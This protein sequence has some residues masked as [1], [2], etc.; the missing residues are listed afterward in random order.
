MILDP[1]AKARA[2]RKKFRQF[3][4]EKYRLGNR[5]DKLFG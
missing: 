1:K 5:I 3:E 2:D 4:F